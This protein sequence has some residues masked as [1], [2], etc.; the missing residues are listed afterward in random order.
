MFKHVTI[1]KRSLK[2]PGTAKE[3]LRNCQGGGGASAPCAAATSGST[4]RREKTGNNGDPKQLPPLLTFL[5][6]GDNVVTC[7]TTKNTAS[8]L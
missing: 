4:S 2:S 1:T 6:G 5:T 8:L 3:G 7:K